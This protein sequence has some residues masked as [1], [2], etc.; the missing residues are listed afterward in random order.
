MQSAT[1]RALLLFGLWIAQPAAASASDF[2]E[3]LEAFALEARQSGISQA[4]L[5]AALADVERIPAVIELDRRQPKE[6]GDFCGYMTARLTEVRFARGRAMLRE[7][8]ALLHRVSSRY[9]VPARVLV[10]L[11]GLESNFG[12]YQGDYRVIGALATL[13]HDGRRGSLFRKQLLAALR[14]VD[15]GHQQP[16]SLMGSWAGAMG[17]VQLMPTTFLDYA[18]DY[19]GDGRKDIWSSLPDAFA[20]A[21]NYLKRAGWRSGQSWGREVQLPAA[22]GGDRGALAKTRSLADWRGAG[23]VRID[24][25]ALPSAGMRGRIVMPAAKSPDAFL[26][27]A[28][29]ETLLRWNHSIFFGLSVGALADE[30]SEVAS[31]RAC[32]R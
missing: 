5:D 24:G 31:L 26:V 13:A 27:Y 3:W 18:V 10:A 1:A 21:A 8:R 32:R 20:S 15:E 12:D 22:L 11:W 4:T 25:G 9:G 28:N 17:H 19:D 29:F 16:E 14:I 30:I 23:V 6:P 7:H 2:A